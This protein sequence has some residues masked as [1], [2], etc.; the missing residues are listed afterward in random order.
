M[1]IAEV[2]CNHLGDL[3][4]A[5]R[6]IEVATSF[7]NVTTVKFQKRD[8]ATLLTEEQRNAPHPAPHN[9]YGPTYGE[10]RE[11]LE[12][13]LDQH[14]ELKEACEARGATYTCS[15]WDAPSFE[16][17]A[18]LEP[19]LIKIPSASN[20]N[21]D[22]LE[23]ACRHFPGPIHISLGMTTRAEEA[24]IVEVFRRHGRL[25]DLVLYACTSGYP[26]QPAEAY[27]LEILRLREAYGAEVGGIG[28]S[29]HHNGISL[30][31]VAFTL[32]AD[33]LERHFTLDRT[34]KGTDHAAS[35]EPDGLRRLRRDLD[36]AA[37]ALQARPTEIVEVER[38]QRAKLKWL[39]GNV[40]ASPAA[41]SH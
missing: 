1:L 37:Q 29:G 16:E 15:V 41:G 14:R 2:G 24:T 36:Y 30:D 34:W 17:I 27:L 31:L 9:S 6:F 39:R 35:L 13:D 28:Y 38:P 40:G 3:D 4:V 33:Y 12:L 11:F 23:A 8:V 10:H 25:G 21:P 20:T 19:E 26:V 7:C 22:L 32:G 18:S 5:K